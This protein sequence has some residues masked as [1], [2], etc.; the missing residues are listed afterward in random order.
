M[1]ADSPVVEGTITGFKDVRELERA[2]AAD[3]ALYEKVMADINAAEA[4]PAAVQTPA[5]VAPEDPAQEF[6]TIKVP[7]TLIED[8]GTYAVNRSPEEAIAEVVKGNKEKDRYINTLRTG[9]SGLET[10]L[11]QK[12]AELEEEKANRQRLANQLKELSAKP[13]V[14]QPGA[15]APAAA[16]F[17]PAG[18]PPLPPE[19]V[20]PVGDD[21]LD[22]ELRDKWQKDRQVYD[23]AISVRLKVLDSVGKN[24]EMTTGKIQD[25]SKEIE[26][27]KTGVTKVTTDA[28][29]SK[30][31]TKRI[32]STNRE[33]EEIEAF[34]AQNRNLFTSEREIFEIEADY[35]N[36]LGGIASALGAKD[37]IYVKGTNTIK[38]EVLRA[39]GEYQRGT[40]EIGKKLID[41]M[42]AQGRGIPADI[43][44]L[45]RIYKVR[46][47][48][49]MYGQRRPDGTIAA[50]P[51][52]R[53]LNFA[54]NDDA[55]L[56]KPKPAP[57]P[58]PAPQPAPKITPRDQ[59][60]ARR[61][62]VDRVL[63]ENKGRA[64]ESDPSVS[65]AQTDVAN[66]STND[67]FKIISKPPTQRTE[68]D[69][70]LLRQVEAFYNMK[71]GELDLS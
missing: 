15:P 19:P 69:K 60:M 53:A 29:L 12:E 62:S 40:S 68:S 71:P 52:D 14:Q 24:L 34:R 55:T 54:M 48:R 31:Q 49:N 26:T 39:V 10:Q 3:P 6:L 27:L 67:Y 59:E 45:S 21:F 22:P 47:Y 43:E 57:A 63:N 42:Q 32:E 2:M 61:E 51:Y 23:A 36:F 64:A 44:D 7:K 37:G 41:E 1:A 17:N 18:L 28:E 46:E 56:F 38:P 11:T 4:A 33:F 30:N 70:T 50:L 25:L 16:E 13:P 9:R 66:F 8:M 35:I 5:E 58:Q 20:M 65:A